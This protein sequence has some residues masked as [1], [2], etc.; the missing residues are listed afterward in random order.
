MAARLRERYEKEVVP[1]LTKR[2]GYSSRM[3]VPVLYKVVL[4]MGLGAA[5]ADP[6][7]VEVG[8]ADLARITGQKPVITRAKK[9]I[10]NFKLRRGLAIGAMVTLRKE[11]MYEFVDR[12][13]NVALPRVRDFKGVSPKS[14]D[15]RGNYTMGLR[16]HTIFPEVDL[17]KVEKVVGM[18]LTFVTTAR[19]REEAKGLLAGLGMPFRDK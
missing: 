15:D 14:F 6:K 12:F 16:E 13:F 4:N 19:T 10:S 18:N 2:F 17:D 1:V 7:V 8:A 9:A 11:R 3:Q 5:T